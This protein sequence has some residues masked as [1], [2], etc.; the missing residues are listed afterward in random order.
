MEW[1]T[2][3]T[4][5]LFLFTYCIPSLY[6]LSEIL[7]LAARMPA[8]LSSSLRKMW[9]WSEEKWMFLG[10]D[11]K[12]EKGR[13]DLKSVLDFL[14]ASNKQGLL[15]PASWDGI[16]LRDSE[17]SDRLNLFLK[18]LWRSSSKSQV[19]V[20]YSH[21]ITMHTTNKLNF[22]FSCNPA[23]VLVSS[24][25]PF[26]LYVI[27]MRNGYLNSTTREERMGCFLVP[28]NHVYLQKFTCLFGFIPASN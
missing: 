16:Y 3:N 11:E 13:R 22:S 21:H 24:P 7:Y 18:F 14:A 4:H 2:V 1:Q 20:A 8:R 19:A 23:A 12:E 5:F 17:L 25:P 15:F 27:G 6:L 10:T 28:S 26:L 9:M